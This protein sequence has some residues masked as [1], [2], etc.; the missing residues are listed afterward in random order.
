MQTEEI[1]QRL[2]EDGIEHLWV[3]YHDY[4]GV[5]GAKSVPKEGF[6]SALEN[7]VMFALANLNF[8]VT[9]RQAPDA[10]LGAES[11]DFL[12]KP[13]PRTY[14]VLPHYPGV[15]RMHTWMLSTD[16]SP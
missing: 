12:A 5:A 10:V 11:G 8:D 2:E 4:S 13:D 14:A 9:D 15:A 1:L 16:G 3:T 6:R 7:G